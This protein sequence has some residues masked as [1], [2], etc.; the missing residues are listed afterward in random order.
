[1]RCRLRLFLWF[2]F[3]GSLIGLAY[4]SLLGRIFRGAA[5]IGGAV[6]AIDGAAIAC[7]I[8]TSE[9]FLLRTRYQ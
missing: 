3:G 7:P 9:I 6:G 5:L 1:M 4:G 8:V 2:V